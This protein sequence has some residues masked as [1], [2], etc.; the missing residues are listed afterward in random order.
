M[1][2]SWRVL[3]PLAAII[4]YMV[5][6]VLPTF[7]PSSA[8]VDAF[9]VGWEALT[10]WERVE[11]DRWLLSA[12]WLANPAI[13]V[14]VV[15]TLLGR[16]LLGA[17][18]AGCALMLSLPVLVRVPEIVAVYP[19]YSAWCGSAVL[20]MTGCALALFRRPPVMDRRA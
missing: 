6:L 17:V 10:A 2:G 15:A 8:G 7:G 14:S 3:I 18:A 5:S 9:Q 13:W 4:L 12:A 11:A 20:L 16:P 1:D 19:G